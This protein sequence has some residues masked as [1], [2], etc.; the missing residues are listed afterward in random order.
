MS[1]QEDR[2]LL[3]MAAK[4]AGITILRWGKTAGAFIGDGSAWSP[5]T[6]DGDAL[7]LAATTGLTVR[8]YLNEMQAF[9]LGYRRTKACEH[10]KYDPDKPPHDQS[11]KMAAARRAI[12]RSAAEIG[13]SMP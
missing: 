1:S 2:E 4:A 10:Y 12:V 3:E 13:G 5:L 9:A 11:G 7:R 6:D 8:P